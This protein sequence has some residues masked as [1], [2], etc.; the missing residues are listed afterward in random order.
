[1]RVRTAAAVVVL[2]FGLVACGSSDGSS[3][4]STSAASP[5]LVKACA[6]L[7]AGDWAALSDAADDPAIASVPPVADDLPEMPSSSA[8]LE[9][10]LNNTGIFGDAAGRATYHEARPP[11]WTD[12]HI[13]ADALRALKT[14][15]ATCARDVDGFPVD[16]DAG[17][18]E[19]VAEGAINH[20]S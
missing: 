17:L 8:T 10:Y 11:G 9:D 1:M 16:P 18:Q 13:R 19:Q 2:S 7:E 5:A 15:W 4:D 20:F 12:A 6:D 3:S 14:A